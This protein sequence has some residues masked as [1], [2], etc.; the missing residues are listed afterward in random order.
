[1]R[2]KAC[3]VYSRKPLIFTQQS[4]ASSFLAWCTTGSAIY[5]SGTQSLD[6]LKYFLNQSIVHF[7]I[8]CFSS[9]CPLRI[10][11]L[12]LSLLCLK[13]SPLPLLPL[14]PSSKANSFIRP[15]ATRPGGVTLAFSCLGRYSIISSI[16]AHSHDSVCLHERKHNVLTVKGKIIHDVCESM[17]R[18]ILFKWRRA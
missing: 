9:F 15:L 13:S 7:F 17:A 3:H 10:K 12:S 6:T 2:V 16:L 11:S 5:N 18:K 14:R 8:S 1:M 4:K